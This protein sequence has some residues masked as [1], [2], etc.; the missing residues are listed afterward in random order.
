MDQL[1]KGD[2]Q[3]TNPLRSVLNKNKQPVY[4]RPSFKSAKEAQKAI[5][6]NWT[7]EFNEDFASSSHVL[8]PREQMAM[9]SAFRPPVDWVSDYQRQFVQNNS[10]PLDDKLM[11]QFDEAFMNLSWEDQFNKFSDEKFFDETSFESAWKKASGYDEYNIFDDNFKTF[12]PSDKIMEVTDYQFE[13]HNPY[14]D[15]EDP[16][17]LAVELNR[18]GSLSEAALALEAALQRDQNNSKAWTLLGSVQAEN[19]KESPA[20]VALQNAVRIDPHDVTALM[21]L[22]VSYT[23]E[24]YDMQAFKTLNQWISHK[25]PNLANAQKIDISVASMYEIYETTLNLFL[26]AARLEFKNNQIDADVQVGLGILFYN[27]GQYDKAIDCFNTALNIRPYD[28]L[29]WNRL[30][31]TL[32]NSGKSEEAID[33]YYNALNIKPSFVRARYNLGVSCMNIGCYKEAIEHFLGA[34]KLHQ[35]NSQNVKNISLNLWETLRRTLILFDRRDLSDKA[36]TGTDLNI[37]R[38]EFEF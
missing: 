35:T 33:A 9:E 30:G 28:Y 38:P 23:N 15:H 3:G 17:A 6:N 32:A 31:A 7:N 10:L 20:I 13:P 2:C 12:Q 4:V 19:E 34:L 5:S 21:M 8:N 18:N 14:I 24:S 29:L 37:F 27:S 22:A 16:Y 1:F 26:E 25:Y 11:K 36:I